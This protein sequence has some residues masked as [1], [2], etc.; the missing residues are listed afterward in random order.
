MQGSA[1]SRRLESLLDPERKAQ[2]E[3]NDR[4]M[5]GETAD[6][7]AVRVMPADIRTWTTPPMPDN[8]LEQ[9]D[10]RGAP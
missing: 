4:A 3:A 9:H 8:L 10:V 2:C 6:E 1:V 7:R 5:M